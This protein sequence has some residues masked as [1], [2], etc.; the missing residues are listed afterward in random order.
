MYKTNGAAVADTT[1]KRFVSFREIAGFLWQNAERGARC[2]R[3]ERYDKV[4]R[5]LN[6]AQFH[7]IAFRLL[8][9]RIYDEIRGQERGGGMRSQQMHENPRENSVAH[10][11]EAWLTGRRREE[12]L[13]V[14]FAR[15]VSPFRSLQAGMPAVS[16][17]AGAIP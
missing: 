7:D 12:P 13:F 3:A 2:M 1:N 15:S 6:D 17:S 9:K 16:L 10:G 14:A 8:V 5:Y 4:T 11:E